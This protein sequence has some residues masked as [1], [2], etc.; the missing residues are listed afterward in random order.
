M[1]TLLLPLTFEETYS[2]TEEKLVKDSVLVR[3]SIDVKRHLGHS[4]CYKGKYLMGPGVQVQSFS[5]LSSC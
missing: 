1:K 3:G 2:Q 4:N 5:P